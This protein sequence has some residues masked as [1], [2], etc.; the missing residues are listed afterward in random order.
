MAV[1]VQN[2]AETYFISD[3]H[4][5]HKNILK[6]SDGFR[7]NV[8]SVTTITDHDD[9]IIKRCNAI[10]QPHDILYVLGDLGN[11]WRRLNDI[12]CTKRVVLGNHDHES[13]KVYLS[14]LDD[15][16]IMPMHKFQYCW[17]TH[18]PIHPAELYGK[19]N[20]HGHVHTHS[21]R[22]EN[23]VNVSVDMTAGYPINIKQIKRGEFKTHHIETVDHVFEQLVKLKIM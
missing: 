16:T 11:N 15:A 17:I 8:L 14:Q 22:D 3:P 23:Y 18:C 9:E 12:N 13:M 10:V 7:G 20:I 19:K 5:G 1:V 2:S 6:F 4:F 21:V